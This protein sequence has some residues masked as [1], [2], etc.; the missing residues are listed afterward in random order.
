[1]A[2]EFSVSFMIGAALGSGFANSFKAAQQYLKKTSK[3]TNDLNKQQSDL[4]AQQKALN[5]A[6][7]FGTINAQSY[8]NAMKQVAISMA[9]VKNAQKGLQFKQK[10]DIAR[11]KRR[12]AMADAASW[13]AMTYALSEPIQ[14]AMKFQSA[15]SDVKKVVDMTGD[16]FKAMSS[17]IIAMSQRI[18]MTAEEISKIV[19]SG[20]QAGIDKSE[21]LDFAES[22]AKMGVAFDITAEQAGDMMAK[23]RTAFKMGQSDVVVLSDKI[24]Y[25]GNTTAASADKISD[26]VT[27]IGPLGD[28]GGVASGEIAAL[29]ASM[30]S[31][32]VESEVAATGIKNLVLGMTAG[33]GATARQAEAFASLGLDASEMSKRM[34]VDA[35]GAI[36]DVLSAIKQM[37]KASQ[38]NV[39]K[40]LFGK[41]S[42]SAIAPLLSNLDA[43]QDNFNKVG[44]ATQ[45]TGSME[46]EYAERSKTAENAMQLMKNAVNGLSIELGTG[47][48]PILTEGVQGV[49]EIV[50]A[51]GSFMSE[52]PALAQ[53]IYG[54]VIGFTAMMTVVS[55]VRIGL[56][57]LQ[58]GYYL[59]RIGMVAFKGVLLACNA[60]IK[61]LT[62]TQWLLN[63]AL[64]ANPIGLVIIALAAL[65]TAVY[66][67]YT[68]FDQV[69]EFCTSMWESPIAAVLAFIGGPIGLLIYAGM[70]I[71]A[72]WEQVKSWFTLLWENPKAAL[73]QFYDWVMSKLGGLF[74]W[75]AGKWEW[76]KSIFSMPIQANIQA[77]ASGNGQSI[78]VG[79]NARG[80]IYGKGA[81]LTT[82]AEDSAEAAIPLDGSS[83]ALNLYRQTG[84]LLG[85]NPTSSGTAISASYSPQI[86]VQGNADKNVIASALREAQNEFEDMLYSFE[87]KQRRKSYA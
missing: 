32:G 51:F 9:Q 81:F 61:I 11:D 64:N 79:A 35:K 3:S 12:S 46:A 14:Q 67:V 75:I 59:V 19:A 24:N 31:T 18:P 43:L 26:V 86:I 70:G 80:G 28:V 69:K 82:F 77:S 16:E 17:D 54:L 10:F 6:V 58:Q 85:L 1:M 44:D 34:Q 63:A 41:E 78:E 56:F 4:E 29:G 49:T 53:G 7:S 45:Y 76:I 22:A 72:N 47:L 52:H 15:M 20:G 38:A 66:T 48:L 25:L 42:I 13:G 50:K 83:R 84:E 33:E 60:G 71:I 8:Q 37:D 23:W 27:R 73:S 2:S 21:L 57:T 62:A 40:D 68:Y 36:L 5:E 87:H 39:L 74:D 30:V 55:L 65:A